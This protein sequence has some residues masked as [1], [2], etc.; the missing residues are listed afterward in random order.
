MNI[1]KIQEHTLCPYVNSSYVPMN[2]GEETL[3]GALN[4]LSFEY[5]SMEQEFLR[6][7]QQNQ[8]LVPDI[9]SELASRRSH[10]VRCLRPSSDP[11]RTLWRR[12]FLGNS[13]RC[14][15]STAGA[16]YQALSP[17]ITLTLFWEFLQVVE[18]L[19]CPV[20]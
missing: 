18:R 3:P 5:F 2:T 13:V 6:S 16:S 11:R 7:R 20:M 1:S 4:R 14:R 9:E 8:Y 10:C 19:S 12:P 17:L 15:R